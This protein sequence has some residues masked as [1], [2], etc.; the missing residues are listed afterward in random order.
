MVPEGDYYAV[1]LYELDATK[2]G[3][4]QPNRIYSARELIRRDDT[5]RAK[6][7]PNVQALV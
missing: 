1:L 3:A 7:G 4:R 5:C 2:T 6:N